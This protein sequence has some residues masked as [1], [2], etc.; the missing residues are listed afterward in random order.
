MKQSI[1]ELLNL[2]ER[3]QQEQDYES[4]AECYLQ[5]GKEYKK[6]GRTAKAVYYLNR[7][8][9]LVGGEDGLYDKFKEEDDQAMR[10]VEDLEDIQEPYE[11]T[12][13][14]QVAEKSADLNDL[15]KMQWLVLTMSRFCKLFQVIS[16][17]PEFG[18][19]KKLD[20]IVTYLSEGLY[21][22]LNEDQ[23]WEIS[24]YNDFMEEVFESFV[25]SDY[26]K[27]IEIPGQKSFVP[28]D[29]ESGDGTYFFGAA[30]N[31]LQDFIFDELDEDGVEME[32]AA[33]GILADYYYRTSDAD[34]QGE[35]K[36]KEEI[37]R[38]LSDYDFVKE[39]PDQ[40][41][42]QERVE[43]YKGIMLI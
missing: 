40:E 43:G 32:F 18:E 8:D 27:E 42:F 36:V 30:F 1:E 35:Q 34:I 41:K 33:C 24:E 14:R 37:D 26:T 16:G 25:M 31:A 3:A 7:F 28:A 4:V 11:K 17:L 9:N 5:L 21:G 13:Q 23:E 10:W 6:E 29:L 22:E 2:V 20:K 39:E 15:Q 12:I 38:I 19:L